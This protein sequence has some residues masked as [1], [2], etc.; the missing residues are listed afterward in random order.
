MK[1]GLDGKS[2]RSYNNSA[3]LQKRH[4]VPEGLM[5][6]IAGASPPP[7]KSTV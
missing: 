3:Y 4:N 6:N 5:K 1:R 7:E 2:W